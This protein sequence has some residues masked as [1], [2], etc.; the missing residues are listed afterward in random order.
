MVTLALNT[1]NVVVVVAN[2]RATE[3]FKKIVLCFKM[4]IMCKK[5]FFYRNNSMWSDCLA[6]RAYGSQ[7]ICIVHLQHLNL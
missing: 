2:T 5:T 6:D 1:S 4:T 3:V 7:A